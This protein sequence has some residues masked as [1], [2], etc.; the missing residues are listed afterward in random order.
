V[1]YTKQRRFADAVTA[2]Q[3]ALRLK[4]DYADAHF[5]LGHAYYE[6]H[7]Q[8]KATASYSEALRINAN[9][10]P[11]AANLGWLYFNLG[12]FAQAADVLAQAIKAAPKWDANTPEPKADYPRLYLKLGAALDR[13][14]DLKSALKQYRVLRGFDRIAAEKLLKIIKG[15]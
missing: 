12:K 3:D 4:P 7:E 8:E 15:K 5:G 13:A 6:L 9:H 2:C 1:T 10:V 11:A 14:G